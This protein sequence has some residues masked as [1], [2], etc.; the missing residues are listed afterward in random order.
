MVWCFVIF[1]F[2]KSYDL[3]AVIMKLL[4]GWYAGIFSSVRR[5]S[6]QSPARVAIA[7]GVFPGLRCGRGIW[8]KWRTM[9]PRKQKAWWWI[10]MSS[11]QV[12]LF[13]SVSSHNNSV[14]FL[15]R[16]LFLFAQGNLKLLT[17][18][19][20]LNPNSAIVYFVCYGGDVENRCRTDCLEW[21]LLFTRWAMRHR[22]LVVLLLDTGEGALSF[23]CCPPW[24][25]PLSWRSPLSS[26]PATRLSQPSFS[27]P[28]GISLP[29]LAG[30][31]Q[32]VRKPIFPTSNSCLTIQC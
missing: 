19:N 8:D 10:G 15:I 27:N 24:V 30:C 6:C 9:P 1:A 13:P 12:I 25:C 3:C 18:V 22:V 5:K 2:G 16:V 28:W 4:C 17:K 23:L 31:C 14:S 7:A 20:L 21:S 26:T 32:S 29:D 11:G